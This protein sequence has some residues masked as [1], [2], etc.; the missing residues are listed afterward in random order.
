MSYPAAGT[1]P[2]I[3]AKLGS[4]IIFAVGMTLLISYFLIGFALRNSPQDTEA[5]QAPRG[6][7]GG[8]AAGTLTSTSAPG[9]DGRFRSDDGV[10]HVDGPDLGSDAAAVHRRHGPALGSTGEPSTPCAG[11]AIG[12]RW[13]S[14]LPSLR[15]L[16]PARCFRAR[17]SA[18]FRFLTDFWW[19]FL[20]AGALAA[21]SR[22]CWRAGS[23]GA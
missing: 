22:S 23:P 10:A 12:P 15:A 8:S 5:V 14:G 6:S 7:R 1:L 3:R 18:T 2:T 4:T 19:Q 9:H 11:R 21:R 20:L 17:M 16:G 13:S